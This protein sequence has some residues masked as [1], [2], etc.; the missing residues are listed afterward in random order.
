MKTIVLLSLLLG[1]TTIAFSQVSKGQFLIGSSINLESIKNENSSFGN[2]ESTTYYISPNIG[3]FIFNQIA[4]G[5]RIDFRSYNNKSESL[6]THQTNTSI[7]PFIRYYFLPKQKKVNAFIDA[8]YIHNK[9]KWS[10]DTNPGYFVKAKGYYFY[11][12]A[13]IFLTS[14]IALEF[15]FGYKHTKSDDFGN[16][17]ENKLSSGVGLQIHLGQNKNQ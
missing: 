8:S 5:L 17:K 11:G 1:L 13:A 15:T 10:S 4:T 2:N 6:E 3:Y 12:G 7:A 9:S 14:Q 16:T